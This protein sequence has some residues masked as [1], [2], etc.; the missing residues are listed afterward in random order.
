M[1]TEKPPTAPPYS[2]GTGTAAADSVIVFQ[3]PGEEE[4]NNVAEKRADSPPPT[5]TEHE[6]SADHQPVPEA[7]TTKSGEHP[8]SPSAIA[9]ARTRIYG[10]YEVDAEVRSPS[11]LNQNSKNLTPLPEILHRPLGHPARALPVHV[12][13]PKR[14]HT[15]VTIDIH[16]TQALQVALDSQRRLP[17]LYPVRL[18]LY[19]RFTKRLRERR[20]FI[21]S[22]A[23]MFVGVMIF[24][25]FIIAVLWLNKPGPKDKIAYE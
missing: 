13:R 5:S 3:L 12:P 21:I 14:G 6:K 19:R 7:P 1:D 22:A 17:P 23:L 10:R 24:V 15:R 4:S 20:C 2:Q 16:P 18:N 9:P 8:K 11:L 25:C